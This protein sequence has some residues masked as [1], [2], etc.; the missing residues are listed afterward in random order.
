MELTY[1]KQ[2]DYLIPNLSLPESPKVGKYGMLRRTYL[3]NHHR[4]LYTGMMLSQ[5]LNSHLEEI[6]QQANE[7]VEA[8]IRQMAKEHG[9]TESMK[10]SNQMEWVRQMNNIHNVAEKIILKEFVYS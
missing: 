10:A 7:M 3:R 6:D 1:T 9:V 4:G 2:G 5:T 8:L